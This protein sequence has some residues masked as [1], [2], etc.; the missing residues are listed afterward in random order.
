MSETIAIEVG[1]HAPDVVAT[2]DAISAALHI[3]DLR[4]LEDVP[5]PGEPWPEGIR[6]LFREEVSTRTTEITCSGGELTVRMFSM[7]SP[8]DVE[9]AIAIVTYLAEHA[10]VT[11]V[12]S[13]SRGTIALDELANL[14]SAAWV[15]NQLRSGHAALGT[16]VREGK[17]PIEVPGPNRSFVVGARVLLQLGTDQPHVQLLESIRRVQWIPI[18]SGSVFTAHA[19]SDHREIKLAMWLGE[20]VVFPDVEFC[21]I[22]IDP[23]ADKPAVF[24][25]PAARVPELAGERWTAIDERQGILADVGSGWPAIVAAAR[26]FEVTP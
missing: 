5:P 7:A 6:H 25:I 22:A 12:A 23:G 9:L 1:D 14:Y 16:L 20:E 8:E 26:A 17:G 19:T 15:D 2:L 11:E 4:S 3:N 21:G 18:R 13:D 24:M 10:G